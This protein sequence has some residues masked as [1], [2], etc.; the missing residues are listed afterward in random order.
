M[1]LFREAIMERKKASEF[2]LGLAVGTT[3][4]SA[5][6]PVPVDPWRA[7]SPLPNFGRSDFIVRRGWIIYANVTARRLRAGC[8]RAR[9]N[10]PKGR[11]LL[12]LHAGLA[13]RI[14]SMERRNAR[15][16]NNQSRSRSG[17]LAVKCAFSHVSRNGFDIGPGPIFAGRNISAGRYPRRPTAG[18]CFRERNRSCAVV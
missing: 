5:L 8:A 2:P 14:R 18:S 10:S 3:Q 12:R 13:A 16:L 17:P 9:W 15:P 11:K 4:P 1:L 6:R 7:I